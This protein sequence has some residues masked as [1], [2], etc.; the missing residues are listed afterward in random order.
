MNQVIQISGEHESQVLEYF[1]SAGIAL[2]DI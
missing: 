2:F 1:C